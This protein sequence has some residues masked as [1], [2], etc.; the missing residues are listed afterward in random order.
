MD[1]DLLF[2]GTPDR[3]SVPA[4]DADA[5]GVQVASSSSASSV[6]QDGL[7]AGGGCLRSACDPTLVAQKDAA[8]PPRSTVA[9]QGAPPA[10]KACR[11]TPMPSL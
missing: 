3:W 9:G 11:R 8:S 6:G 1:D 4:I 7:R 2:T 10:V 5:Q